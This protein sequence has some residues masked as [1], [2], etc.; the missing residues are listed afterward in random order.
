MREIRVEPNGRILRGIAL[1]YDEVVIMSSPRPRH[2]QV[3]HL[4]VFDKDSILDVGALFA[5]PLLINHRDDRPI[6]R[7]R[8]SR[9]TERG[10]EIEA[11]LV[12]SD[13]EIQGLTRR[14]AAGI[15]A[16][17]SI[18]FHP[19]HE[20]D[21]WAAPA[22]SGPAL[23]LVTRRGVKIREVSIVVWPAYAGAVIEG[24]YERTARGE[25]RHVESVVAIA[26]ARHTMAEVAA[27]RR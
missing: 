24:I 20:D 12:G 25:T 13:D 8:S 15:Q 23:P 27:R 10:L 9:S 7:V 21:I 2:G 1:P 6:G 22:R 3:V 17:M 19:S 4:E 11:E 14:I 16:R 5:R 26:L 18:G